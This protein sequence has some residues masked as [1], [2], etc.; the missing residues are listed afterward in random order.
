MSWSQQFGEQVAYSL[1][2]WH[3]V[4]KTSSLFMHHSSWCSW[5]IF[6]QASTGAVTRLHSLG[7]HSDIYFLTC[8]TKGSSS[9]VTMR[10]LTWS[11]AYNHPFGILSPI[12]CWSCKRL[13]RWDVKWKLD[14]KDNLVAFKFVC[15]GKGGNH[16]F[17][18][19]KPESFVLYFG[20][21]HVWEGSWYEEIIPVIWIVVTWA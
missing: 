20:K 2:L 3:L 9:K 1:G 7:A 19:K 10:H 18:M 15:D 8:E 11:H 12:Q 6:K 16:K 5:F 17:I 13:R 21:N 14:G 4:P